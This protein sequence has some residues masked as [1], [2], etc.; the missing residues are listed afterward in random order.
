M[1]VNF[2]IPTTEIKVGSGSFTVRGMNS[3]DLTF[4]VTHYLEDMKATVAKYGDKVVISTSSIFGVK[5]V[6]FNTD[7]GMQDF[8]VI[9]LD[10][11]A[12]SR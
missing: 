6:S 1:A 11:A 5:K 7:V 3:E 10:T 12:A 2:E 8:G 9:A 4:L